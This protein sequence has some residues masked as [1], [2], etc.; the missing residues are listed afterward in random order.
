[1]LKSLQLTQVDVVRTILVHTCFKT[2]LHTAIH[3]KAGQESVHMCH[4]ARK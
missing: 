1:M 3:F 2:V 4:Y